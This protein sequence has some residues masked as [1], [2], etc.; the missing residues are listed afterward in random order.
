MKNRLVER[1][2]CA[3]PLLSTT[4]IANAHRDDPES[5]S[6]EW[7]ALFRDDIS[8]FLDDALISASIDLNRPRELP[9]RR[10]VPYVAFTDPSGGR[11]D[12]YTMAIGHRDNETFVCDVVTGV[13]PPCDPKQVTR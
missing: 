4:I 10:G 2:N 1:Q 5:A 12:A 3:N 8:S 6:S 9:P 11:S 7:D 13:Y